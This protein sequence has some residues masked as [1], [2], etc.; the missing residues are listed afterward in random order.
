MIYNS[1]YDFEWKEILRFLVP[2]FQ[3]VLA[4]ADEQQR[5]R[6]PGAHQPGDDGLGVRRRVRDDTPHGTLDQRVRLRAREEIVPEPHPLGQRLD[7]PRIR[8][9]S[10]GL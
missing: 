5:H 6:S 9:G 3:D 7:Q 2:T 1:L 10:T 8:V 4:F